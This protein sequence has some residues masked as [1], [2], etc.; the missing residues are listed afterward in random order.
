MNT[1]ELLEK[2]AQEAYA[3][4]MEKIA[5]TPKSK[6]PFAITK[7][8]QTSPDAAFK[9]VR[10]ALFAQTR[11]GPTL[12]RELK[13]SVAFGGKMSDAVSK[14]TIVSKQLGYA[15]GLAKNSFA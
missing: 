11:L 3:D 10:D 13:N 5:L 12:K 1:N 8:I 6:L 2:I 4:E 14:S 15:R 9:N 7:R